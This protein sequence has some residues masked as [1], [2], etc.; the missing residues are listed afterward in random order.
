MNKKWFKEA[1]FGMMI[2]WGLYSL[3]G[4]EWQGK[5]MEYIGEWIMSKFQIPNKEYER[6]ADVFNPIYFDAE[7]WVHTAKAAGMISYGIFDES[8]K[9]YVAEMKDVSDKYVYTF[10]ELL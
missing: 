8:S 2:H 4:G 7:E 3:L 9:D 1:G 6:L 5:R 10:S